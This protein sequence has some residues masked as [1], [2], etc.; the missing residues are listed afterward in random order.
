[1][2]NLGYNDLSVNDTIVVE[3]KNKKRLPNKLESKN[4]RF[5]IFGE[6]MTGEKILIPAFTFDELKE[7]GW[8]GV[9]NKDIRNSQ[10]HFEWKSHASNLTKTE[11][12]LNFQEIYLLDK[13]GVIK[14]VFNDKE[15][16][17][18]KTLKITLHNTSKNYE[19][20]AKHYDFNHD[21]K[22][23]AIK[24]KTKETLRNKS[25]IV[26]DT[27]NSLKAAYKDWDDNNSTTKV[28]KPLTLEEK[29]EKF[30][31]AIDKLHKTDNSINIFT[32]E[33][34]NQ[35]N[36]DINF[37]ICQKELL[38]E[39]RKKTGIEFTI[40]ELEEFK[41]K[42]EI[43][44][45][46]EELKEVKIEICSTKGNI[47][48][49]SEIIKASIKKQ[50][51]NKILNLSLMEIKLNFNKKTDLTIKDEIEKIKKLKED[52]LKLTNE[53]SELIIFQT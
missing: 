25:L 7:N 18:E 9:P 10:H 28:T 38:H 48:K 52:Y 44:E 47:K 33:T 23:K 17:E 5:L 41:V 40:E 13:D 27:N 12:L 34:N 51:N 22:L 26:K 24:E 3:F 30:K 21:E 37:V 42:V 4:P 1:M 16:F 6:L 35:D 43:I 31:K 50:S 14:N 19:S 53:E 39:L 32:Y 20:L 49:T 15:H 11:R 36:Q 46:T 29:A 45:P 8:N 2:P